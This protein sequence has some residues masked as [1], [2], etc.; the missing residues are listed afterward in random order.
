MFEQDEKQLA[1]FLRQY[2][3]SA[4]N[5]IAAALARLTPKQKAAALQ[6]LR[7]RLKPLYELANAV[8]HAAADPKLPE[9]AAPVLNASNAELTT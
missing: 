4:K 1:A 5:E 3:T 8:L 2:G 6:D 9:A 7:E